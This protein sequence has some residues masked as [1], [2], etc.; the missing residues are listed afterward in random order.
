MKKQ[1]HYVKILLSFVFVVVLVGCGSWQK[2]T[3]ISYQA[4]GETL[5]SVKTVLKAQCDSGEL[6]ADKCA[7]I[8]NAYN[9]AITIYE[10]A[11]TMAISA[12][13]LEDKAKQKRYAEM[14]QDILNLLAS[15]DK[16]RRETMYLPFNNEARKF[17]P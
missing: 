9:K 6:P 15:I 4:I 2:T 16:I 8:Q 1:P 13:D 10:E 3:L 12:V 5:I 17:N 11:G 7:E 14:K